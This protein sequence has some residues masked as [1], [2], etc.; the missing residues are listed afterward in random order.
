MP[1]KRSQKRSYKL[2]KVRISAAL[3]LST[4]GSVTVL[5]GTFT[6]ISDAQYRLMSTKSTWDLIGQTEGEGPIVVGL[7]H[8]DYTVTEIKEALEAAAAISQG[9]KI[10]NEKANRLVRIIGTF[11][12]GANSVL[13]DG[14]PVKT[15]FNWNIAIGDASVL[16]AYND[17]GSAL[18]TGAVL[19]VNGEVWVRDA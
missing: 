1:T 10:A 16:F 3:G 4:L 14:R 19:N 8:S 12:G 2:R 15:R 7:A 11:G 17:S 5:T 18:T 6:G 13:N 9:D